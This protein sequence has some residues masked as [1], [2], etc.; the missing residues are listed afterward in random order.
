M[1]NMVILNHHRLFIYI[2]ISNLGSYHD[3]NIFRHLG[4]YKNWH[5]YFTHGDDYFENM[6]GNASYMGKYMFLMHMIG[7]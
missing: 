4:V 7:H 3:V 2:D 1:N 5:Q 6:L